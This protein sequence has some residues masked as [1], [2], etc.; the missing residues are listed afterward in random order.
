MIFRKKKAMDWIKE[1]EKFAKKGNLDKAIECYKKAYDESDKVKEGESPQRIKAIALDNM[2]AIYA[3]VG[4]YEDALDCFNKSL[5]FILAEK[6]ID[7]DPLSEDAEVPNEIWLQIIRDPLAY[8]CYGDK[9]TVLSDL[10]FE[11]GGAR[12]DELI[13]QSR[14]MLDKLLETIPVS[15]EH[16]QIASRLARVR[17][18]V[19]FAIAQRKYPE[20]FIGT[21]KGVI[22]PLPR[23]KEVYKELGYT[24]KEIKFDFKCMGINQEIT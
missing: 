7:K 4:K 14:R 5:S 20:E 11:N 18:N 16:M 3:M 24:E 1:G 13:H 2:G 12:F 19:I 17:Y 21:D 8:L 23:I 15:T 22:A 6:G 10:A 9:A